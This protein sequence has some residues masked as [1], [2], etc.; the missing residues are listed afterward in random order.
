VLSE[1][2]RVDRI[3]RMATHKRTHAH[4][5]VA[6]RLINTHTHTYTHTHTFAQVSHQGRV[7]LTACITT[8][9]LSDS[10]ISC[11]VAAGIGTNAEIALTVLLADSKFLKEYV[12]EYEKE[13]LDRAG[14]V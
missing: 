7:G 1:Q 2:P 12:D 5:K 8:K 14:D 10:S 6:G 4:N 13:N 11:T 9:W 3:D